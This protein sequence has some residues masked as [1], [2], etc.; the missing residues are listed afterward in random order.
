MATKTKKLSAPQQY[1]IDFRATVAKLAKT[2][3]GAIT[4]DDV[5]ARIG[6]PPQGGKALGALM[7]AAAHD[8]GLVQV[9]QERSKQ[10]S[11]R[12]AYNKA[13]KVPSGF[14]KFS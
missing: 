9:G 6:T 12:G 11:R 4:V 5:I 1:N 13:W 2:R 10:P 3:K 7:N 14:R 8:V